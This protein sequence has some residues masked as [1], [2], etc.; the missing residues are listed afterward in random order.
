MTGRS[1]ASIFRRARSV[2]GSRPSTL[3][4]NSR[5]SDMVTLISVAPSTTWLLVTMGPVGRD[6]EARSEPAHD[7]RSRPAE[8]PEVVEWLVLVG[9]GVPLAHSRVDVDDGR[10][11]GLGQLDPRRRRDG[12]LAYDGRLLGPQLRRGLRQ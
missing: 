10:F 12:A 2:L 5:P 8:P 9:G 6:D 7:P 1:W 3:A 11:Q 4:A